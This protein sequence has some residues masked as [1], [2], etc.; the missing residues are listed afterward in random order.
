MK[1]I[2]FFWLSMGTLTLGAQTVVI[3][4]AVLK[5]KLVSTSCADFNDDGIYDGDVD[6]NDDG[7]I[8]VSEAQ[9]VLRLKLNNTSLPSPNAFADATG[10]NAFTACRELNVAFN[11]LTQ[12]DAVMPALEI[13]KINNNALNSLTLN[14]LG[15]LNDLD[16]SQNNLGALDLQ[17][18][19][20]L[21]SLRTDFNPLGSVNLEFTPELSFLSLQSCSLSALNLSSTPA[22]LF[23]KLSDNSF[24]PNLT[25]LVNLKT[26]IVRN[27]GLQNLDLSSNTNLLSVD[28]SQNSF[29]NFV[30]PLSPSLNSVTISSCPNLSSLNLNYL[31]ALTFLE[32]NNNPSLQFIFAKNGQATY[33]QLSLNGLSELQYICTDSGAFDDFQTALG[34]STVPVNDYCTIPPG[35]NYNT[36]RGTAR[37]DTAQNGCDS[38]DFPVR[39]LKLKVEGGANYAT[40]SANDGSYTLFSNT[41]VN[42]TLSP[43]VENTANTTVTPSQQ[44]ITF[45]QV[46]GQ[47]QV[48]DVCL[49]PNGVYHDIEVAV[50]PLYLFQPGITNTLVVV[51]RNKGNQV[52]NGTFSLNYDASRCTYLNATVAPSQTGG[53]LVTWNY[54]ALQPWATQ[55]VY[56]Q[57]AVNAETDATPVLVGDTLSFQTTVSPSDTDQQPVDDTFVIE[58]PVIDSF[59]PNSLL[60][61][62]GPQL[63]TA[64]IGSYLH[65]MINFENTGASQAA[66]VVVRLEINGSEFDIDSWQIL[67]TSAPT[68]V[69]QKDALI[70]IFFPN[71][72]IDTGGHGN[73]LM[74]IRSKNSLGNGDAVNNR[75]DIFFDYNLPL[76]TGI[77]QT[78]YQDLSL[79]ETADYVG[80]TIAPNPVVDLLSI[81]ATAKIKKIEVYDSQGRLLQIRYAQGLQ[82]TLDFQQKASGVYWIKVDTENGSAVKKLIKN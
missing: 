40:F 13:L 57:L 27:M 71:L 75:A 21:E 60:C 18:V 9:V 4:D 55:T 68:V 56:V 26:L 59:E 5:N 8:Q 65:Y 58:Q 61:L 69:R 22:L 33:Q 63:P 81:N 29:S 82:E 46:N 32:C 67:D 24:T 35:G 54:T 11:Q 77:T 76:N 45:S 23:L 38:N 3:P 28:L 51:L 52:S 6:A 17:P 79:P 1:K 34:A 53:G 48:V 47:E 16:C 66:Q 64:A 72:Q 43:W 49:A 39:Y 31:K 78:V 14:G 73:V 10:L 50:A 12:F 7:E 70:D 15:F 19:A 44:T 2:L 42:Y 20:L 36:I 37:W 25:A 30:F 62:Q 80:I 74:R 41:G